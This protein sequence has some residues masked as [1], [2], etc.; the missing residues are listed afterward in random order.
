MDEMDSMSDDKMKMMCEECEI[1][2]EDRTTKE[3]MMDKMKEQMSSI[4]D[5]YTANMK[6]R[7]SDDMSGGNI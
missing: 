1:Q 2:M 3:D 5:E 6:S 4:N 7:I